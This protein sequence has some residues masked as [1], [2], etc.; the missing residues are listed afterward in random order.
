MGRWGENGIAGV[1]GWKGF[2]QQRPPA[3][4]AWGSRGGVIRSAAMGVPP[5][6]T[7]CGTL[8]PLCSPGLQSVS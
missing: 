3:Q 4:E 5:I 7:W 1:K 8:K 6:Q 2:E